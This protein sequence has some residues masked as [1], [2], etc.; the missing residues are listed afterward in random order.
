MSR[1]LARRRRRSAERTASVSASAR[2]RMRDGCDTRKKT[3]RACVWRARGAAPGC[4]ES[5]GDGS[6]WWR[7]QV[8]PGQRRDD[9]WVVAEQKRQRKTVKRRIEDLAAVLEESVVYADDPDERSDC[10]SSRRVSPSCS[11]PGQAGN[12]LGARRQR[13]CVD[14]L[15][16]ARGRRT[17]RG[18]AD[19]AH[20]E[21]R[22]LAR[23]C[24]S[25]RGVFPSSFPS[26][27]ALIGRSCRRRSPSAT[28]TG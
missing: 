19:R 23:G 2:T 16:G 10:P 20:P 26:A 28:R 7:M 15:H 11:T 24:R 14:R 12:S 3:R 1:R 8:A 4:L 13:R 25:P 27:Q 21:G 22:V 5:R 6:G 17:T 18:H 9:T